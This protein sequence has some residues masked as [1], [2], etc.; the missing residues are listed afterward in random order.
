MSPF[1]SELYQHCYSCWELCN[2]GEQFFVFDYGGNGEACNSIPIKMPPWNFYNLWTMAEICKKSGSDTFVLF[3]H[4]WSI[5]KKWLLQKHV[6]SCSK[7]QKQEASNYEGHGNINEQ[8]YMKKWSSRCLYLPVSAIQLMTSTSR[9]QA[10]GI[11]ILID[12]GE[13]IRI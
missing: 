2:M 4:K 11:C 5:F 1:F 12:N 10:N 3:L 6:V 9:C 13:S 7:K 8:V